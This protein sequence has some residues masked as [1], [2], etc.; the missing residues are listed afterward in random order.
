MIKLRSFPC[1]G[2]SGFWGNKQGR[3]NPKPPSFSSYFQEKFLVLV[4][5]AFYSFTK[6]FLCFSSYFSE[7][8]SFSFYFV[9]CPFCLKLSNAGVALVS[10]QPPLS[11]L[12][13]LLNNIID[14]LHIYFT[15]LNFTL[16]LLLELQVHFYCQSLSSQIPWT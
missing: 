11:L 16:Q 15:N 1:C 4:I 7:C 13:S 8:C 3:G 9:G 12:C 10:S 2:S 5:V 6:I 14:Y